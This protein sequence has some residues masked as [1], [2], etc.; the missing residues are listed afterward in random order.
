MGST[1]VNHAQS[2]FPL[3]VCLLD[4][5]IK[6]A[7]QLGTGKALS[8]AILLIWKLSVFGIMSVTVMFIGL[9]TRKAMQ[10]MLNSS[11]SVNILGATMTRIWVELC[12]AAKQTQ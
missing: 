1:S 4:I 11:L 2:T 5:G 8:T 10:N 9:T 12:L 3:L 6:K 7:T